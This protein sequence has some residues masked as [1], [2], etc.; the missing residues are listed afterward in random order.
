MKKKTKPLRSYIKRSLNQFFKDLD[1]TD[2]AD[3]HAQ[4]IQEMEHQLFRYVIKH[5][6]GNRTRAAAILGISRSTLQKK[7]KKYGIA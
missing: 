4:M 3:L 7:L 1:G 5:T 6:K 2:P